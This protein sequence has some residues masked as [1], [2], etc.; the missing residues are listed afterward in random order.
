MT[1]DYT[2]NTDKIAKN[3]R[4]L[5]PFRSFFISES[6]VYSVVGILMVINGHLCSA[7]SAHSVVLHFQHIPLFQCLVA[8]K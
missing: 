2:D 8:L 1:T 3:F 6:S 4:N 5:S 7:F